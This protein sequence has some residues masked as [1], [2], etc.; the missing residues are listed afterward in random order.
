MQLEYAEIQNG[1]Q[2]ILQYSEQK[3]NTTIKIQAEKKSSENFTENFTENLRKIY[4]LLENNPQISFNELSKLV[5]ISRRA[6]I[7][8]VNKLKDKGLLERIGADKG[9]YWRVIKIS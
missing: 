1:F 6:I 7:N 2:T 9:G 8:N 3:I 4:E 5:G